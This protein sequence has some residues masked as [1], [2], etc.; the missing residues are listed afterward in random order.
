MLTSCEITMEKNVLLFFTIYCCFFASCYQTTKEDGN[1][2]L[3]DTIIDSEDFHI[4]IHDFIRIPFF[5]IQESIFQS[6]VNL[7]MVLKN[8]TGR[9]IIG[10]F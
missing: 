4:S 10:Y 7:L 5:N 8:R 2:H 1:I 3:K 9:W 6:R